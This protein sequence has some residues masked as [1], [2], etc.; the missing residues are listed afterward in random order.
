MTATG[1]NAF[2][3]MMRPGL[4]AFR[5]TQS[6]SPSDVLGWANANTAETR[7]RDCKLS[8]SAIRCRLHGIRHS[9]CAEEPLSCD[10]PCVL[11]SHS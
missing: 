3:Y 5:Q 9:S 4:A 2:E 7:V 1:V 10:Q 11:G 6:I 8:S